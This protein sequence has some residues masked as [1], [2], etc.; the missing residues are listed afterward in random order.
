MELL[1]ARLGVRTFWTEVPKL[2]LAFIPSTYGWKDKLSDGHRGPDVVTSLLRSR[3]E[4][5]E[6][7]NVEEDPECQ[8]RGYDLVW[9]YARPDGAVDHTRIEVKWDRYPQTGNFAFETLS[10]VE[11]NVPGCFLTSTADEWWYGFPAI[12]TIYVLPLARTRAWFLARGAHYP[13]KVTSSWDGNRRWHTE[14]ALSP[15]RDVLAAI[16]KIE[17]VKFA[18]EKGEPAGTGSGTG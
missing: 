4:T 18:E 10:V 9:I 8:V 2:S 3:P 14:F 12:G 15:I 1:L 7:R 11:E 13:R 16:P 17:V 5:R 6:V